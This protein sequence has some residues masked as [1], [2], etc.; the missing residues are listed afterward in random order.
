MRRPETTA[1]IEG[2]GLGVAAVQMFFFAGFAFAAALAF[3]AAARRYRSVE[4]YRPAAPPPAAGE[5]GES[6]E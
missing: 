1:A 2:A 6:V 4:H 3:G 5:S